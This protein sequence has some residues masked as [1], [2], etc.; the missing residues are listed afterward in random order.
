[1]KKGYAHE[2]GDGGGVDGDCWT[3][4]WKLGVTPRIKFF[5]WKLLHD[6]LP[7]KNNLVGRYV[8]VDPVCARPA[9]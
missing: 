1:M 9:I 8:D 5:L 2:M 6:I 7:T 3:W 4:V